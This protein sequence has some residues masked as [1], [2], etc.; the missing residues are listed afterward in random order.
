MFHR[1]KKPKIPLFLSFHYIR[2]V[3]E[4]FLFW[5][6][7][8]TFIQIS[9]QV[10]IRFDI[11]LRLSLNFDVLVAKAVYVSLDPSQTFLVIRRYFSGIVV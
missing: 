8:Q 9:V 1:P 7:Q 6:E 10:R 4:N 11:I 5:T 2:A 3:M